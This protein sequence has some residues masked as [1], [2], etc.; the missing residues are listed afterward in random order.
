MDLERLAKRVGWQKPKISRIKL[1]EVRQ[2]FAAAIA[3]AIAH[4]ARAKL[5]EGITK[6]DQ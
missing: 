1:E 2:L 5:F 3:D 4:D 6:E